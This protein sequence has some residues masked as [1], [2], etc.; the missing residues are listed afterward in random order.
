MAESKTGN[1]KLCTLS[2]YNAC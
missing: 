2:W 1:L